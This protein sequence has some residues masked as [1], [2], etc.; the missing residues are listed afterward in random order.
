[1]G[2]RVG[3]WLGAIVFQVGADAV[4][5]ALASAVGQ[6]PNGNPQRLAIKWIDGDFG[7]EFRNQLIPIRR[8]VPVLATVKFDR[9]R[10]VTR[11]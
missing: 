5:D 9:K 6:R 11:Q 10:R 2:R 3:G 1:M 7:Q 4:D 8:H